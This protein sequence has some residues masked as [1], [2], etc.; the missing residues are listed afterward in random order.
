MTTISS[1]RRKKSFSVRTA[2]FVVFA[3]VFLLLAGLWR[4]GATRLFWKLGEPL[5]AA[6][7]ALFHGEVE[8]LRS[9]LATAEARLADRDALYAENIELKRLLGRHDTIQFVRAAVLMRPPG[10]PYDT[11][12]IDLGLADG[13]APGQ[14]VSAGGTTLIG[15]VTEVYEST[16]RITLFSAPGT[17]YQSHIDQ[18]T[19]I[20]LEGQGGGSLKG[21]IP[22][23]VSV[24]Q[25]DR[26]ALQG[27][28]EGFV[29]AVSY[30]EHREGESFQTVYVHLPVNLFELN[31][32]EVW[33]NYGL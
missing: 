26:V 31:Y 23:G 15:S 12:V 5:L 33:K 2:A 6:R 25:G 8:E 18:K 30:V 11:F 16:A 22:T 20:S 14:V 10:V 28:S 21:Q 19:P 13:I 29:G 17:T 9:K 7:A 32:V 24:R 1:N 3:L 27:V 4:D